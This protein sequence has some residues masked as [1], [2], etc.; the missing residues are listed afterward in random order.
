MYES[1]ER[2]LASPLARDE[3]AGQAVG[4]RAQKR[5]AHV[6]WRRDYGN[7]SERSV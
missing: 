5:L 1:A 7:R 6:D 4:A 2:P 3:T